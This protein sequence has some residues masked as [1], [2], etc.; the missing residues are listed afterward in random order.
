MVKYV[1][2]SESQVY[3]ENKTNNLLKFIHFGG[4]MKLLNTTQNHQ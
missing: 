1:F 3:T 4:F 2:I